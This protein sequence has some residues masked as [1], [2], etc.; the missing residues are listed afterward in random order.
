[1]LIR[2]ENRLSMLNSCK[3]SQA[4]S[5]RMSPISPISGTIIYPQRTNN[6]IEQFFR[7]LKRSHRRRTGNSTM[8]RVLNSMLADIPLV[9]NLDNSEYM[10][11]L[12][13]G[14]ANLEDLFSKVDRMQTEK[15]EKTVNRND[16]ILPRF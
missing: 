10:E 14:K 16:R 5:E 9:K 2:C 8:S 13:D 6:I 4:R 12:L 1:M 11:T 15:E 3:T 7:D